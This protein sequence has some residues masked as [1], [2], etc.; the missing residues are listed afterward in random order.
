MSTTFHQAKHFPSVRGKIS[1]S[2]TSMTW[3]TMHLG[4][5]KA[6]PLSAPPEHQLQLQLSHGL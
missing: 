6:A 4:R 5:S 1:K 3:Q 2:L